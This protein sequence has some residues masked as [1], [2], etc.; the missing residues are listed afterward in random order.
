MVWGRPRRSGFARC[1]RTDRS[2]VTLFQ[3]GRSP[4]RWSTRAIARQIHRPNLSQLG[5][6]SLELIRSIPRRSLGTTPRAFTQKGK[7]QPP[8]LILALL[9]MAA[10]AGRRGYQGIIDA[11]WGEARSLRLKLPSITESTAPAFCNARHKLHRGLMP[12]LVQATAKKTVDA[13]GE[14]G[15]WKGRRLCAIDGSKISLRRSPELWKAY[16][17]PTGAHTPQLLAMVLLDVVLRAPLHFLTAPYRSSEQREMPPLLRNVPQNAILLMDRGFEAFEI[18]CLLAKRGIDHVIRCRTKGGFKLIEQFVQTGQ[19]E[20]WITVLRP[21]GSDP[22]TPKE[23]RLRVVRCELPKGRVEVLVTT[24][25]AV[26]AS[27]S[28]VADLYWKRWRI[29]GHFAY[30]KAKWLS[31]LQFHSESQAGVEQEFGA[32][33][34][35]M[36]I[37]SSLVATAGAR[38]GVPFDEIARKPA[39]LGLKDFLTRLVLLADPQTFQ[40]ELAALLARMARR[41][42]RFR[43]GRSY[44]RVSFAPTPKWGSKGANGTHRNGRTR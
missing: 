22:K 5:D 27:A 11:I 31:A 29:E 33:L 30:Q 6:V 9:Y 38:H 28:E 1:D 3:E 44:P 18:F 21:R 24:L 16:G 2:L 8:L 15:T 35:F 32:I 23:I 41:R 25:T 13:A 39:L 10:D 17:G 20:A 43:P 42:Y 26:E 40:A 36:A 4:C 14:T 12:R 37:T 34:L 7:W 19:R